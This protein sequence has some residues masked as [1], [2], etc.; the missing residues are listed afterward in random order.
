MT[1]EEEIFHYR[2]H[3]YGYGLISYLTGANMRTV[4]RV[5]ME[6]IEREKDN[7]R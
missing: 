3:D 5:L 1:L 2:N 7:G 6:I 4:R